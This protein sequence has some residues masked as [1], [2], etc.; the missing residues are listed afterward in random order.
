MVA[1]QDALHVSKLM[2]TPSPQV[3]RHTLLAK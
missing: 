2:A 3:T 1:G